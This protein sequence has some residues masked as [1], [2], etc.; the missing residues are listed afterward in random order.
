MTID[1]L[2]PE[3]QIIYQKFFL[4]FPVTIFNQLVQRVKPSLLRTYNEIYE[5]HIQK[6]HHKD[7]N[8]PDCVYSSII[9]FQQDTFL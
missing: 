2:Q 5:K 8:Q 9:H 4:A 3:S 7:R 6:L 1:Y